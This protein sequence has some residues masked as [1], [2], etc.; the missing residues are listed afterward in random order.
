MARYSVYVRP[1]ARKEIDRL[2]GHVRQRVR[3]AVLGLQDDLRSSRGK[4]MEYDLGPD[5]E[6]WRLRLDVWRVVYLI[7]QEWDQVYV[8]AVRKRPPYQYEDLASLLAGMG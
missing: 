3:R 7:D 1:Q 4:C 8:L 5:R 6:L 2:P